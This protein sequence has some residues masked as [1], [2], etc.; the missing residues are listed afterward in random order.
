MDDGELRLH[1]LLHLDK[2][3]LAELNCS[4]SNAEETQMG[5]DQSIQGDDPLFESGASVRYRT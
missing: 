4:K 1:Q 3:G 2:G 5:G